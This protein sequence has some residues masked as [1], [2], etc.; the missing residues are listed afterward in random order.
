VFLVVLSVSTTYGNLKMKILQNRTVSVISFYAFLKRGVANVTYF[1]ER[2]AGFKK[3][4][5]PMA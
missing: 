5:E 2:G 1:Y 3:G 4:W